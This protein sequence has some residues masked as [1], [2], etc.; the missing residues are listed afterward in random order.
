VFSVA[1]PQAVAAAPA[2]EAFAARPAIEGV[3]I[4]P[5]GRR[6]TIVRTEGGRGVVVVRD[7]GSD[8]AAGQRIVLVEP[9]H[10]RVGWCHWATNVRLLC[11][12][13]AMVKDGMRVYS[14]S[15]LVGVD[16]DGRNQ[17]VLIQD[18]EVAQGQYQ[19]HVLH[20]NPGTPDTV[21]VEADEGLSSEQRL[22]IAGG[23]TFF[24]NVGT[25]GLPAVFELN[26][27]TGRMGMRQRSRAPIRH[28]IAD[29]KG[30]VRL[31]WGQQGAEKSYFARLDG[32]SGWRRLAKFEVFSRDN[33]FDPIA[34]SRDA[35]NKAYA[36]GDS[37]GRDAL[38]LIDLTD[39]DDPELLFAHPV[40]DV[41]DPM[42][43]ADGRL[44]GVR[45]D[46]DYPMMDF[47][48]ARASGLMAGL[49]RAM[50]G[51]E[52]V[53][54]DS[55]RD[56]SVY[57]IKS[58]SDVQPAFFTVFDVATGKLTRLGKSDSELRPADLARMRPIDYPARDGT[59]IPGYLTIPL[60]AGEKNL[61]L[62]V[63]PHG[64]PI[65][66]DTWR[67]DF[68]VQFLASRGYA[69][70]QMNFRGS[71]GYGSEWFFAAHQ[72]WGGLT[73]Q[74]VVDGT[75]WAIREGIANPRRVC[76]VGWSFG[77][78]LALVAAQRNS[79]LF[80]CSVDIAGVSD[81]GLLLYERSRF[82]NGSDV[83][84]RQLGVDKDKLR[85]DSP[86]LHATEF[87]VPLLMIH[88]DH[89]AQV[90]IEQSKA[91]D[92]ALSHAGKPHWLVEIQGGDHA[93][94]SETDRA[95]LLRNLESFLG[96][97]LHGVDELVH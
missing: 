29:S 57:V 40:V 53:V 49:R 30:R 93:L 8:S 50:P 12:F 83:A 94:S 87:S 42:F 76:I 17:R 72:D 6:L 85:R 16:A 88:G 67:Y 7:W 3:T 41:A 59:R 62:I 45:Y 37:D 5:D 27:V 9:G 55:S 95:T 86:R 24:G 28:W 65:H 70:L 18:S 13:W 2:I 92:E 74:D 15:R 31:G 51:L 56:E 78:Y 54:V 97:H 39:K 63:L 69:V 81:L 60:N 64:G 52:S 25:H 84:K 66:R 89:D 23:A 34:I 79:D 61:P 36:I 68:L 32:D 10:A 22:Y 47:V 71:S 21:L 44:L 90:S 19:D 82:I 20:W 58:E 1:V 38:W 4:S 46:T 33:H 77:G 35:P 73:Y 96:D 48:D 14:G 75:R 91:M 11:S 43:A 80:Q 26:V